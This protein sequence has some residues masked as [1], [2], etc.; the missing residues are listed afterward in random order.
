MLALVGGM[1][2]LANPRC[3]GLVPIC[4]PNS[5]MSARRSLARNALISRWTSSPRVAESAGSPA[6]G[7]ARVRPFSGPAHADRLTEIYGEVLR[8]FFSDHS[9]SR[10]WVTR[11]GDELTV[12]FDAH[13]SHWWFKGAVRELKSW[14][15]LN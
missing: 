5:C 15:P 12:G 7:L 11:W 8:L 6:D 10:F 13:H 3:S 2:A 9:D 1:E 14:H 4:R